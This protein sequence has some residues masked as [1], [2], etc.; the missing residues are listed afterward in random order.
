M[1][2]KHTDT[3]IK[4][5]DCPNYRQMCMEKVVLFVQKPVFVVNHV[6]RCN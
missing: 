1:F 2:E 4:I 6:D 3:V 5:L